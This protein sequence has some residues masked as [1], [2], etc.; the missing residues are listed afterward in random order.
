MLCESLHML[1]DPA[2]QAQGKPNLGNQFIANETHSFVWD[3]S[4]SPS[5]SSGNPAQ[6]S[7]SRWASGWPLQAGG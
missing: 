3:F 1:E 6:L 4:A 2:N 7:E 5:T